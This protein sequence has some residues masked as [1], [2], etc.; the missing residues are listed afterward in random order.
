MSAVLFR[1]VYAWSRFI[2]REQ[3]MD[4]DRMGKVIPYSLISKV[5]PLIYLK[6]VLVLQINQ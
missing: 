4:S 5:L 2:A 3:Q 6:Y 1:V